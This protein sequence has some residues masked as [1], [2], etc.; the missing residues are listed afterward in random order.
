GRDPAG[1]GGDGR[2]GRGVVARQVGDPGGGRPRLHRPLP[3]AVAH[4]GRATPAG[5]GTDP[6]PGTQIEPGLRDGPRP[7]PRRPG[8]RDLTP[9]VSPARPASPRPHAA[10]AR[11]PT[12][13]GR[14]VTP[15]A[16]G[17][18]HL[19]R[20]VTALAAQGPAHGTRPRRGAAT[21]LAG[22]SRP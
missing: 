4:R 1:P 22:P 7:H 10:V 19:T 21:R 5:R 3:G 15:A 2:P 12:S 17:P 11:A 20:D 6:L 18:A 9:H 16:H 14:D 13:L 8:S